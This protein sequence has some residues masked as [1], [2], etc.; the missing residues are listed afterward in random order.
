MSKPSS[1]LDLSTSLIVSR[2]QEIFPPEN[3]FFAPGKV[4]GESIDLLTRYRPNLS[5]LITEQ[6]YAPD[7]LKPEV[8]DRITL[9][10]ENMR[11]KEDLPTCVNNSKSG[12]R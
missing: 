8:D 9:K 11:K 6:F 10:V 1:T 4:F 3:L 2:I 7:F 12:P 5:K